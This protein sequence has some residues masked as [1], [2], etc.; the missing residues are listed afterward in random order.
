MNATVRMRNLMVMA[1]ADGS[2]G[3]R[4]VNY[5]T[6][7][8]VE[9]GLGEAE[10]R[11]AVRFALEDGAS[12]RLPTDPAG[13]ESLLADLLQMMA[14]DGRLSESEKRLFAVCAAKLGFGLTEVDALIDRLLRK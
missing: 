3:E 2:L 5:L 12:I 6:D 14:A 1:L 7:R 13:A 10:L 11:D 8:C 4:E 9:L